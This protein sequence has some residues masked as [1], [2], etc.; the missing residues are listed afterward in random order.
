MSLVSTD[1]AR[2]VVEL[3]GVIGVE[4]LDRLPGLIAECERRWS[5]KVMAPF[6]SLSYSYVAPATGADGTPVVLKAGVPHDE[7]TTEIEALKLFEGR[8][9]VKL[10]EADIDLGVMVLERLTPGVRLAGQIDDQRATADAARVM[11]KLWRP[12]P[13]DHP[14]PTVGDRSAGLTRLRDHFGGGAG[15][16]P[17]KLIE[18]AER[19]FTELIDTEVEPVLLHGDLHHDNILSS[20]RAPWIA[21]DPKGVVGEATYETSAFLRNHLLSRSEPARLLSRRVDQ[22]VDELGFQRERIVGWGLAQ[23]VLSAWWSYED[24]GHGWEAAIA[25]AELFATQEPTPL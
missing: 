21:I 14:F 20:T 2:K 25:C 10:L 15:P 11:R 7:L 19:L 12:V 17:S 3:H 1:I 5:L 6:P 24:H 13:P 8:G 9:C 22:F 18:R 4:W 23:A 16:F